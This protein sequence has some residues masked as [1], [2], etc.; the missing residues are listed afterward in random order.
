VFN[1]DEPTDENTVE[2]NEEEPPVT[3]QSKPDEQ[4]LIPELFNARWSKKRSPVSEF[5]FVQCNVSNF[6][7]GE[8]IKIIIEERDAQSNQKSLT[9][10]NSTVKETTGMIKIPW[11]IKSENYQS[12]LTNNKSDL[13][14]KPVEF[15]FTLEA[16]GQKVFNASP[17]I[18]TTTYE[19]IPKTKSGQAVIDGRVFILTD[20]EQKEHK[21]KV[22]DGTLIFENVILGAYTIKSTEKMKLTLSDNGLEFIKYSEGIEYDEIDSNKVMMYDDSAGH[23]TIGYGH[24]VHR[25]NMNG[26]EK[27][28]FID[29]ITQSR[30]EELLKSDVKRFENLVNTRVKVELSKTQ[31]DA[32]VSFAFNIPLG[33]DPTESTLLRNLNE[34]DY[35]GVPTQ[36]ERWCKETKTVNVKDDKGNVIKTEKQKIVNKGLL[37]R[38]KREG[39][40]FETGEY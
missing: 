29:G 4:Q 8:A 12:T 3:E 11:D 10:I 37:N 39:K 17:L 28:E 19:I 21:A 40:L 36:L 20:A 1:P 32:L 5:V 2:E 34:G 15:H 24:L 23:A 27:Q 7:V 25:G 35:K 22:K 26:T 33:M 31:F 14:E 18:L 13:P 9:V 38:R 6:E 30:A 16:A